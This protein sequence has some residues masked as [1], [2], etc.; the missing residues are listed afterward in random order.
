[1]SEFQTETTKGIMVTNSR[2]VALVAAENAVRHQFRMDEARIEQLQRRQAV[3][4]FADAVLD[5]LGGNHLAPSFLP[6][7]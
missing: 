5:D 3:A 1:M 2:D 4:S 7:L 6:L